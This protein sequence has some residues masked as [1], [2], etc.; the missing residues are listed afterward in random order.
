MELAFGALDPRHDV[1]RSELDGGADLEH[2]A[3]RTPTP[4]A[5]TRRG[6]RRSRRRRRRRRS[7]GNVWVASAAERELVEQADDGVAAS[8]RRPIDRSAAPGSS[9]PG[10]CGSSAGG[11]GSRCRGAATP[12]SRR[13][14]TRRERCP[15][16]PATPSAVRSASG[17]PDASIDER[18][19]RRDRPSDSVRPARRPVRRPRCR[20][21]CARRRRQG[22]GSTASTRAPARW[23]RSAVSAADGAEAEHDDRFAEQRSGIQGDLQR[24]LD[25]REHRRQARAS[26]DPSGTT[27]AARRRR[28]DPDADGRRRRA[29]PRRASARLSS[30]TPTQL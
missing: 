8:V 20:G 18:H 22:C 3:I 29:S 1:L 12:P 5:S 15:R 19:R 30:T 24:G 4:R 11:G 28:S 7:N 17:L 21:S 6:L 16:A 26:A 14:T 25:E 9:T 10:C 27:S 23:S 2:G 13:T